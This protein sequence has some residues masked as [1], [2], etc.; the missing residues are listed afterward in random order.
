MPQTLLAVRA[1]LADLT[2][3]TPGGDVLTWGDILNDDALQKL[4]NMVHGVAPVTGAAAATDANGNPTPDTTAFPPANYPLGTLFYA[5]S[6]PAAVDDGGMIFRRE[7]G[8]GAEVWVWRWGSFRASNGNGEYQRDADGVQRCAADDVP[9][10]YSSAST[11]VGTW[12][13][14]TAWAATPVAPAPNLGDTPDFNPELPT[15]TRIVPSA[16]SALLR[17]YSVSGG[18]L[19]GDTATVDVTAVGVWKV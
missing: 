18:F 15:G 12:T 1:A 4:L 2:V 3:P 6:Y 19:S 10:T 14:P 13:Y 17:L 16:A 5:T 9:V 8:A 7:G 11:L